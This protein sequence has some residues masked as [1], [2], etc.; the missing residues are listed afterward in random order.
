MGGAV[1]GGAF[2]GTYPT[3]VPDG[4]DDADAGAGARGRWIP[5]TAVDQFGATLARWYGVPDADL[6]AVF[7]NL[8]SFDIADLGFL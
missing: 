1:A 2:Y 7:P 6:E 3:I 5:T 4:P 8:S